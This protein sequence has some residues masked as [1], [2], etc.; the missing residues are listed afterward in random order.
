VTNQPQN[1]RKVMTTSSSEQG[2]E[3]RGGHASSDK[4]FSKLPVVSGRPAAGA[5]ASGGKSTEKPAL[6]GGR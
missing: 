1:L 6:K 3:K 5:S 2:I 4:P